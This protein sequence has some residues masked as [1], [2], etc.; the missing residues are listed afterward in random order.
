MDTLGLTPSTSSPRG[1]SFFLGRPAL[2]PWF[3]WLSVHHLWLLSLSTVSLPSGMLWFGCMDCS[4]FTN[5]KYPVP[6][7]TRPCLWKDLKYSLFYFSWNLFTFL[8]INWG[9]VKELVFILFLRHPED[10]TLLLSITEWKRSIKLRFRIL[11]SMLLICWLIFL[12]ILMTQ[13]KFQHSFTFVSSS[14]ARILFFSIQ[15]NTLTNFYNNHT[16]CSTY[17]GLSPLLNAPHAL[18]PLSFIISLNIQDQA[19]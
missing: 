6:P 16:L 15:K 1:I 7:Q 2:A 3:F 18:F 17:H 14:K 12:W 8:G 4:Y 5:N 19:R 9:N 13:R 11:L 10:P